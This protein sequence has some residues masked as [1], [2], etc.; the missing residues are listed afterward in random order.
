M[1]KQANRP[2]ND[3]LLKVALGEVVERP[4]IWIM[5]QAGRYL[6]SYMKVRKQAGSF[7]NMIAHPQY[8]A[9]V[10]L[11]PIDQLNVDAAIIFSDILV[12]PEAIGLPYDMKPGEGPVFEKIIEDESDI[13]RLHPVKAYSN[14]N[15]TY[16]AIEMVLEKLNNRVPLIGFAGAP[17]TIFCYMTEGKG[18][19]SFSKA[20]ALIYRN[21]ALAH[22][23]LDLITE[24]TITYLKGQ[25]AAGVN[26][27]QLF[28]SW[29]GLL[30]IHTFSEFSLPYIEQICNAIQ[31]VPKIVYAKGAFFALNKL[32]EL[33]T[34]VIGLDWHTPPHMAS[35]LIHR[36]A[37]QGNLDP[38]YLYAS[39]ENIRKAT[40]NMLKEF[41]VGKH[42]VN[43]GHGVFPD[44]PVEGVK[45]FIEAVKSFRYIPG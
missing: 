28:D 43:L 38:A 36:Q 27:V 4:P 35:Q 8:A 44:M 45:T 42:I 7:R 6:P 1:I 5:R 20:R 37:L 23:L 29:A 11:Q 33:D 9:E 14:L 16:E 40:E 10:T 17:W 3:L 24:A 39:P 21:P 18:S 41:P 26:I 32:A 12:I 15:H 22:Q 25:I 34:Q 30:D 19:K 31:E 13:A 2:D